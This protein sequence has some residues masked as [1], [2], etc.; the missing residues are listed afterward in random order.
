MQ[1]L[2]TMC[3]FYNAIQGYSL[4]FT[5]HVILAVGKKIL[6]FFFYLDDVIQALLYRFHTE[7]NTGG[8]GNQ[9]WDIRSIC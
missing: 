6:T 3:L 1:I 4:H 5:I 7:D 8:F 2:K 9:D